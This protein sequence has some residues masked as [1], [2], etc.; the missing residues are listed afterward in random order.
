MAQPERCERKRPPVGF[1]KA[2][3]QV[4]EPELNDV[5]ALLHAPCDQIY[6]QRHH[7]QEREV[8]MKSEPWRLARIIRAFYCWEEDSR[9]DYADRILTSFAF[10]DH[11]LCCWRF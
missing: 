5:I 8:G 2:R 6:R 9:V 7:R 3:W 11:W 1:D 10:A 4:S